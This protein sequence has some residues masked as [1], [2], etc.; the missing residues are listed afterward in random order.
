MYYIILI[1]IIIYVYIYIPF[2]GLKINVW[3]YLGIGALRNVDKQKHESGRVASISDM[4]EA[5]SS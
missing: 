1:K 2:R 5:S 4:Q 3:I